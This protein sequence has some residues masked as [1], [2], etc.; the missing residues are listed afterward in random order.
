MT[1]RTEELR[2]ELQHMADELESFHG[3]VLAVRRRQR[4]HQLLV[5]VAAAVALV[6]TI[7]G[8]V[9]VVNLG[10]NKVVVGDAK[11]EL[12]A[13]RLR[14]VDVVVVPQSPDVQRRLEHSSLVGAYADLPRGA[15]YS[16]LS[17][18]DGQSKLV[19][20]GDIHA[21]ACRLQREEGFAVQAATI[22][23]DITEPLRRELGGDAQVFD[24][25]EGNDTDVELFMTVGATPDQVARIS[26]A[27]NA[28]TDV[29]RFV[30]FDHQAAYDEFKRIFKDQPS[31]IHGTTPDELPT[32]FRLYLNDPAR[33]DRPI[34]RYQNRPGVDTVIRRGGASAFTNLRD[35]AI[36]PTT[37]RPLAEIFMTVAATSSEVAAIR[38][39]L[40][41][42][43]SVLSSTFLDHRD[44][45]D[46]FAKIFKDQP[47]LV[48]ST[49]P[50]DLPE[51]FRVLLRNPE[52]DSLQT[53]YEGRP[54]VDTVIVP[55]VIGEVCK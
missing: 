38:T 16:A 17:G 10:D 8:A 53:R 9:A 29:S 32:S 44:A 31:L 42:D 43:P 52:R 21:A 55:V 46:E 49:K 30:F 51:S 37:R 20:A 45:Y 48:N 54:G 1:M 19:A 41:Q 23:N 2:T 47:A 11:K 18:S 3:D 24:I 35:V 22:D 15:L 4:R 26:R 5:G 39:A 12:S 7:S 33:A 50:S 36:L 13:L 14:H 6:L 25:S 28:D 34:A 27:L 40:A